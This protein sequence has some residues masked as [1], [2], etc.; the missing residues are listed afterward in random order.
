MDRRFPVL[1]F[2]HIRFEPFFGK[3]IDEL[4]FEFLSGGACN[5]NYLMTKK[6]GERYVCRIHTRSKPSTERYIT[7][8]AKD[9]VP[10]VEYLW[11]GEGVSVMAYV[12][13]EH[14]I[15]TPRL[16]RTAGK[17]IAEMSG[18]GRVTQTGPPKQLV[19]MG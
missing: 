18:I 12:D 2:E 5:S 15:P 4:K 6:D 3:G 7:Q 17:L 8:L 9:L 1:P 13:G 14:F 11:V 16:M 10:A 19:W